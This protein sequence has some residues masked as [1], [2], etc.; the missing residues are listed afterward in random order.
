MYNPSHGVL[1]RQLRDPTGQEDLF[2]REARLMQCRRS[3]EQHLR[4]FLFAEALVCFF[5]CI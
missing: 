1:E 5:V 3:D 2:E 4:E